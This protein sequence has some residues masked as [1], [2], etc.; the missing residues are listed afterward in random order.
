MGRVV[1]AILKRISQWKNAAENEPL[2]DHFFYRP[3]WFEEVA[4]GEKVIVLGRKGMGK[5]AVAQHLAAESEPGSR[6]ITLT[7]EALD[8]PSSGTSATFLNDRSNLIRAWKYI[9][10]RAVCEM[11]LESPEARSVNTDGLAKALG[12]QI[13]PQRGISI[14]ERLRRVRIDVGF[15]GLEVGL[16]DGQSNEASLESKIIAMQD[17]IEA[18]IFTASYRVVFDALDK[19]WIEACEDKKQSQYLRLIVSLISAAI[20]VANHFQQT[21]LPRKIHP[22]V[23]LRSDIFSQIR[24]AQ[25]AAWEDDRAIHLVWRSSDLR[26]FAAHRI[27]QTA[28]IVDGQ[29][30]EKRALA[31][32]FQHQT[33][34]LFDIRGSRRR[35]KL[36]DY[37][38]EFSL[39][40][41]RDVVMYLR[42]AA[43]A[44]VS[45]PSYSGTQ[46]ITKDILVECQ[47]EYGRFLRRE[48][49]NEIGGEYPGIAR[50]LNG[51]QA[52]GSDIVSFD[53]FRT[54][55]RERLGPDLSED[56]LIL[57]AERLFELSFFGHV[58]GDGRTLFP[59]KDELSFDPL[60]PLAI[61]PC[62]A[63][64]M[65]LKRADA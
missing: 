47:R 24:N 14:A 41:P 62:Y 35:T 65:N 44:V 64:A 17:F 48:I 6:A 7:L 12:I 30:D 37:V 2:D 59:V 3:P 57:L 15:F 56:D 52:G 34:E 38:V 31:A 53:R 10:L 16:R 39:G 1:T 63:A 50:L 9:I 49:H 40:R 20:D 42:S 5:T 32:S 4:S 25:S 58:M 54:I 29:I 33:A 27:L 13:G 60:S 19:G 51:L 11:F 23:F 43:H 45:R 8:L 46:K 61:H 26:E 22:I 55:A 21:S 18:N 28:K 36:L